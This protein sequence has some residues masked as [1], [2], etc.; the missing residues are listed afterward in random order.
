MAPQHPTVE[1]LKTL[2]IAR[3]MHQYRA[4]RTQNAQRLFNGISYEIERNGVCPNDAS[5]KD[6]WSQFLKRLDREANQQSVWK[7]LVK[8]GL[9]P[10]SEPLPLDFTDATTHLTK[11]A[12]ICN[13]PDM[14]ILR[15][16]IADYVYQGSPNYQG[17]EYLIRNRRWAELRARLKNDETMMKQRLGSLNCIAGDSLGMSIQLIRR[18]YQV[19]RDIDAIVYH[20]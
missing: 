13:E 9:I 6:Y 15:A 7:Q 4:Y 2:Q 1:A 19:N 17:L 16:C 12:E 14:K 18:T 5:L 11:T 20:R 8:D 3:L 10:R